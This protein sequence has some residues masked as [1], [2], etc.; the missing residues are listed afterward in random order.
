MSP[1]SVVIHVLL[2]A[3]NA[4]AYLY[5]LVFCTFILA[6]YVNG[7]I[8]P[9]GCSSSQ[10]YGCGSIVRLILWGGAL[11]EIL[12]FSLVMYLLNRASLRFFR[13]PNADA[14]AKWI[15]VFEAVVGTILFTAIGILTK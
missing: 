13:L 15:L 5:A 2:Y 10:T 12:L 14:T 9:D 11:I 7:W 4:A 1:K 8:I 3:I 6:Q